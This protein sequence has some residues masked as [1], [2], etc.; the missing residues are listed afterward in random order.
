MTGRLTSLAGRVVAALAAALLSL[1][2]AVLPLPAAAQSA[3][4]SQPAAGT[5]TQVA[6]IPADL[7]PLAYSTDTRHEDRVFA[8]PANGLIFL[9]DPQ[10]SCTPQS[11]KP[12]DVVVL[13]ADS[14]RVLASGCPVQGQD[15]VASG[16]AVAP[17][18]AVD[19]TDGLLFFSDNSNASASSPASL[20]VVNEKTLA[21]ETVLDVPSLTSAGPASAS[22]KS[23]T[24]Y[25]NIWGLS[26]DPA[27]DEVLVTHEDTVQQSNP[28]SPATPGLMVD[29]YQVSQ[30][31]KDSGSP[32]TPAWE[33]QISG[34]SG[35]LNIHLGTAD[36]FVLPGLKYLFVPCVLSTPSIAG[37]GAMV[38][39]PSDPGQA[40]ATGLVRLDL[41]ASGC[42]AGVPLCP[43]GV[44]SIAV[45]PGYLTDFF[46]SPGSAGGYGVLQA[47]VAGL[48]GDLQGQQAFDYT[49]LAYDG[50]TNTF[51]G[52]VGLALGTPP[53]DMAF[54][55]NP[56]TGRFY[57]TSPAGMVV[58][59]G[60][61]VPPGTEGEF[62]QYGCDTSYGTDYPVLPPDA[63]N[64]FP[65]VIVGCI[66]DYPIGALSSFKVYADTIPPN[67]NPPAASVDSNTYD[68]AIPSG[69]QSDQAYGANAESSGVHLDFVGSYGGLADNISLDNVPTNEL[70][71]GT[72]DRDLL[73]GWVSQSSL[74]Q[75]NG[76]AAA[77]VLGDANGDTAYSL[78]ACTNAAGAQGC[79]PA[80]PAPPAGTP[81][82]GQAWPA[83]AATCPL[84]TQGGVQE[85][86]AT[87]GLSVTGYDT[88]GNPQPQ[89]IPATEMTDVAQVDCAAAQPAPGSV[90]GAARLQGIGFDSG[91]SPAPAPAPL[92]V[93]IG[94]ALSS[95]SEEPP[96]G[97]APV[98]EATSTA[99]NVRIDVGGAELSIGEIQQVAEA[100][101]GGRPGTASALRRVTISDVRVTDNGS[102]T[103]ICAAVCDGDPQSVV[104]GINTVM[105]SVLQ[106][107]FLPAY[108]PWGT[109]SSTSTSDGT[110]Y[111]IP[112]SAGGYESLVQPSL[113][114]QYSDATFNGYLAS[115]GETTMLPALRLQIAADGSEEPNRLVID[116]APVETDAVDG[117]TISCP[118]GTYAPD[119]SQPLTCVQVPT[120]GGT[121][122]AGSGPQ[123]SAGT[124]GRFVAGSPGYYVPGSG[125]GSGLPFVPAT[126]T[127]PA[128]RVVPM[129]LGSA[130]LPSL[131][132]QPGEWL[133]K[134][135]A[136][137]R[138]LAR[139]P[140]AAAEFVACL[141]RLIAPAVLA[142]RRRRWQ[143]AVSGS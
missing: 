49:A 75:G 37:L 117:V 52:R 123:G 60:A 63:A 79:S 72:G 32:S 141:C 58:V 2:F 143:R 1:G 21:L 18:V 70:P 7:L 31:L 15:L 92:S 47:N 135:F 126:L 55:V 103:V 34:C 20:A 66:S 85:S 43:D 97:N 77:T 127:T 24:E 119:P 129:G 111:R 107:G 88:S 78:G 131:F 4:D 13:D 118:A 82:T 76:Q 121:G 140:A 38:N 84:P 65:R 17:M 53:N 99:R 26:W 87:S 134:A 100:V 89:T 104:A 51:G 6:S 40:E 61:H 122:G 133:K 59:D 46:A 69:Y 112:G 74:Q 105:P 128:G 91:S 23:W 45:A 11:P 57:A 132:G 35:I 25:P 8:D 14:L 9:T 102:T 71:F 106:A 41:S 125:G 54:S 44:S 109:V 62:T 116:L 33:Q 93:A 42:S 138:L 56:D 110:L 86:S 137:F 19:S 22:A 136:G 67:V 101:A 96:T 130:Q 30:V 5:V 114:Q 94:E 80:A 68:G 64:P 27:T 36:A 98:S 90:T 16:A 50:A 142:I 139:S 124:P 48:S 81:T 95:T 28:D 120:G 115:V 108:S 83:G 12:N 113:P 73:A 29:A 39:N 10:S 3:A